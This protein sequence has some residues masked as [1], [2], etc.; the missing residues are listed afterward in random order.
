MLKYISGI[1]EFYSFIEDSHI[2]PKEQYES[3]IIT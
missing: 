1:N 3:G 2:V